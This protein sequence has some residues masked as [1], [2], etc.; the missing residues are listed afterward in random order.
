MM[1][2]N[3]QLWRYFAF[4]PKPEWPCL[5]KSYRCNA[6]VLSDHMLLVRMPRDTV[7]AIAVKIKQ[8]SVKF[9]ACFLCTFSRNSD[10]TSVH[11]NA[12]S[13]ASSCSPYQAII[14]GAVTTLSYIGIW[15][16]A[17]AYCAAVRYNNGL[18]LL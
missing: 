12:L 8:H 2:R 3:L 10:S 7:I 9:D 1:Q 18:L 15:I 11:G 17:M 5:P 16:H 4:M 13:P 6:R 14:R